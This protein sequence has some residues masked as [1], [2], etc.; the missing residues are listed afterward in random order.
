[1]I[2]R[3]QGSDWIC[4][5]TGRK[6]FPL[7]PD[8]TQIDIVDIAHALSLVPRYAGHIATFY[9]VAQHSVLVSNRCSPSEALWGLLHDASE[10]YIGDMPRP[11][12][13]TE[14]M[15]PY[16]DAEKNLQSV[17]C[18]CFGLP[19]TE[20]PSVKEI[21]NRILYTE[22][23]QLFPR[24]HRD[25]RDHA[26]PYPDLEI[27]PLEPKAARSFFLKRYVELTGAIGAIQRMEQ[28]AAQDLSLSKKNNQ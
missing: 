25:W 18:K 14:A 9:S 22:A 27:N 4:T 21:D 19:K 20:P 7:D 12:K 13:R 3:R 11:L 28:Y 16:R 5:Y 1:M 8:V 26:E 24:R 15:A 10:A 2:E 23:A 17:I 6:F